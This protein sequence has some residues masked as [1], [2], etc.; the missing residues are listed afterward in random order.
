MTGEGGREGGREGR[1][2]EGREGRGSEKE[3]WSEFIL[4]SRKH[5]LPTSDFK[6]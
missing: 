2:E 5:T 1:R 4:N 6:L 3:G